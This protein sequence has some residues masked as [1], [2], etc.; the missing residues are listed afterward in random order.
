M[1][2]GWAAAP[3]SARPSRKSEQQEVI[4]RSREEQVRLG[5]SPLPHPRS[6]CYNDAG[7]GEVQWNLGPGCTGCG[8]GEDSE[9]Q[10]RPAWTSAQSWMRAVH[11]SSWPDAR[12]PL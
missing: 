11:P 4:S 5:C 8:S 1:G 10:K 12:A 3:P 9:G 6:V 7:G 2:C